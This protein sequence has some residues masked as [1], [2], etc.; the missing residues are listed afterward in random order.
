MK[1]CLTCNEVFVS[2][3][4]VC[5]GCGV[6]NESHEGFIA[7]APSFAHEGA[8]FKSAYF[9]KLAKLEEQNFWFRARNRLII[10]SLKHYAPDIQSFLE[11]GCGTGFV[12]SGISEA[13]P[14]VKVQGSELFTKGLT[15]AAARLPTTN[16]MQMDA[17]N[18]PFYEEF[19]S[20]GAFDVIE[21]IEEDET[22][23]SQIY[24]ALKPNGLLL[25]TVPQHKWLWSPIDE[26]ACH[27][28]RYTANDLHAKLKNS[29]FN[30]VRSSSFVTT[31]LPVMI[32]SRYIQKLKLKKLKTTDNLNAGLE[33]PS[34]LNFIFEKMLNAE[35]FLIKNGLDFPVGGS[36]LVIVQKSL[37]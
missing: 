31:L 20:I 11:I 28:R 22:V 13:F 21:H 12:I 4:N 30:L 33:L 32:I 34:W 5:S 35:L 2:S 1:Q 8:G 26:D 17:R 16:F 7:Y 18:I 36:R 25:L 14:N 3:S 19:D 6:V 24:K 23:L 29:G 27:V 10:W 15:F 9:E 37:K